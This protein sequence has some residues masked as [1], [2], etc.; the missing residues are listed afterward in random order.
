MSTWPVPGLNIVPPTWTTWPQHGPKRGST[1]HGSKMVATSPN[2]AQEERGSPPT[3]TRGTGFENW[4][5]FQSGCSSK[6]ELRSQKCQINRIRN[7][8]KGNAAQQWI[9]TE[10]NSSNWFG[11]GTH[12]WSIR[13]SWDACKELRWAKLCKPPLPPCKFEK[14]DAWI[15]NQALCKKGVHTHAPLRGQTYQQHVLHWFKAPS[16]KFKHSQTSRVQRKVAIPKH[17]HKHTR[18]LLFHLPHP[19]GVGRWPAVRR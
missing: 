9:G 3:H 4:S 1:W 7:C 13:A 17:I 14:C 11:A 16:Q 5:W 8:V 12:R 10:I 19:S 6:S 2:I 18:L 15:K